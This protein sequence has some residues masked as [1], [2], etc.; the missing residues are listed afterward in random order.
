MQGGSSTLRHLAD[1]DRYFLY[2]FMNSTFWLGVGFYLGQARQ[3]VPSSSLLHSGNTDHATT[4]AGGG[5]T[6]IVDPDKLTVMDADDTNL[7]SAE[8]ALLD[9]PDGGAERLSADAAGTPI[10]A[11]YEA[12]TGVLSLE[13]PATKADF[14]RVLGTVGYDNASPSPTNGERRVSFV[15]SD[16]S[17]DS[18]AATSTLTVT[19]GSDCTIPGTPSNDVLEGTPG[20][21]VICAGAGNDTIRGLEGDDVLKGEGGTDTVDFSGSSA[22]ITA[23]LADGSASGEGSDTLVS[24]ENI[25][26]SAFAD[27]LGGSDANNK[28]VGGSGGDSLVGLAGAD[29]LKGNGGKDTL[30]SRDGAEGN[31]LIDGGGGTDACATD[32][33]EAS[34]LR[35]EQ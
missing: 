21:D 16:G 7:R 15:V 26:G 2:T 14:R 13:G 27:E 9:R 35:C 4:F 20:G 34:I 17:A 28:L 22:A 1:H 30:D 5:S 31:D 29:K 33:T 10:S 25:T 19:A 3:V 8:V 32:A 11:S 18:K 23:S 12:Q 6:P 24:V